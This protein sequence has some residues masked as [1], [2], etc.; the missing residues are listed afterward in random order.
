M[1]GPGLQKNVSPGPSPGFA[2]DISPC[3][4]IQDIIGFKIQDS[5][6]HAVDSVIQVLDSGFCQWNLDSGFESLVGFRS[7]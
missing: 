4:G 3:K 7:P 5:R 1:G 6:F 2:T